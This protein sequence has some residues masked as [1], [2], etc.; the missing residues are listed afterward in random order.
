MP[1]WRSAQHCVRE[2]LYLPGDIS[3]LNARNKHDGNHVALDRTLT[4]HTLTSH[5]TIKLRIPFIIN[6]HLSVN[7]TVLLASYIYDSDCLSA[8]RVVYVRFY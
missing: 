7:P 6:T 8:A 1:R 5:I 4:S 3:D 2:F